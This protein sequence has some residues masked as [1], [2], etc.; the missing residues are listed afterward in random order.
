MQE[1]EYPLED[2]F[3]PPTG[4]LL[5]TDMMPSSY[6]TRPLMLDTGSELAVD[7][8]STYEEPERIDFGQTLQQYLDVCQEGGRDRDVDMSSL[9]TA[10]AQISDTHYRKSS[11][12]YK[13]VVHPSVTMCLQ[14]D[15]LLQDERNTWLLLERLFRCAKDS[16]VPKEKERESEKEVIQRLLGTRK[17]LQV[18]ET[19][20]YW[21]EDLH[22]PVAAEQLRYCEAS[23]TEIGARTRYALRMGQTKKAIVSQLDGDSGCREGKEMVPEDKENE[24]QLLWTIFSLIRAGH[25]S[26]AQDLCVKCGQ[27][28]RA[29][30]L[31]GG[32]PFSDPTLEDLD[33]NSLADRVESEL[34]GNPFRAMWLEICRQLANDDR[35]TDVERAVYGALCGEVSS[36]LS[37]CRFWEDAC[38]AHFKTTLHRCLQSLIYE[39]SLSAIPSV[40]FPYQPPPTTTTPSSAASTS[41]SAIVQRAHEIF[42]SLQ[43]APESTIREESK[44]P[45]RFL[46]TKLIL[47]A[48]TDCDWTAHADNRSSDSLESLLS[49]L[50]DWVQEG[51]VINLSTNENAGFDKACLCPPQIKRFAAH[52]VL[53]LRFIGVSVPDQFYNT[54][55]IAYVRHLMLSNQSPLV[56]LY[57]SRLEPSIQVELYVQYLSNVTHSEERRLCL[58]LAEMYFPDLLRS[59]TTEVVERIRSDVPLES[60]SKP[61]LSSKT[62]PEDEKLLSCLEWVSIPEQFTS[63]AIYQG[64]ALVRHFLVNDK[65]EPARRVLE[66][67][68]RADCLDVVAMLWRD[69][70]PS[71]EELNACHEY[72]CWV[73]YINAHT[74]FSDWFGHLH[75]RPDMPPPLPPSQQLRPDSTVQDVHYNNLCKQYEKA[76]SQWID[77]HEHLVKQAGEALLGVL[78]FHGGWLQD[79]HAVDVPRD[80][81]RSAVLDMLRKKCLPEMVF[82]LNQ[83]YFESEKF[84]L[85]LSLADLVAAEDLRLY[86]LFA[87]DQLKQFLELMRKTAIALWSSQSTDVQLQL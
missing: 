16:Y 54:I 41:P 36:V 63:E 48:L 3:A 57:L 37:V 66:E 86:T 81:N 19:V 26:K 2:E 46:Q 9:L 55:L 12:L 14:E 21:L 53:V 47:F 8:G 76:L 80:S 40:P 11:G 17:D 39:P 58:E 24:Q 22:Q 6:Q 33:P 44:E 28:W 70:P 49:T 84:S 18:L 1:H 83:V 82:L 15:H 43:S 13:S 32:T 35:L 34:A 25:I 77:E 85:S 69:A 42:D 31:A 72:Q 10:F 56:A 20:I 52:L 23:V 45:Y 60:T 87:H 38:W 4:S 67:K 73:A 75:T 50:A 27:P 29:A 51:G 68:I 7:L 74:A 78:Q 59:I 64:N 62:S 65:M 61:W 79:L 71:A 30:S 5:S